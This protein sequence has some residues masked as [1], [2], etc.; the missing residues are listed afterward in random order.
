[1]SA[2]TLPWR[3]AVLG[4]ALAG[5]ALLVTCGSPQGRQTT[6]D[7]LRTG[8]QIAAGAT[9]DQRFSQL[10][11]SWA[12]SIRTADDFLP[13]EEHYIGRAVGASAL[14][15]DRYPLLEDPQVS[16]YVNKVGLAVA[17]SSERVRQTFKGYHFAVLRSD[18]LNAFSA[19]GGFIFITTGMLKETRSEE[20][21][22]GILAHE[23][24]HVTLK[25]GLA[26]I[27]QANMV[28]AGQLMTELYAQHGTDSKKDKRKFKRQLARLSKTFG[29]SADKVVFTLLTGGYG[30]NLEFAADELG[31]RLATAAGFA[32]DGIRSFLSHMPQVGGA[33][34][35]KSTHPAPAA[36]LAR[37]ASLPGDTPPAACLEPRRARHAAVLAR[38]P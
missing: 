22:A 29:E 28:Q 12:R 37:L 4:A 15:G 24:S 30:A 20:E 34:G 18:E 31:T 9:G 11:E 33:G 27:P 5:A 6:G 7:I 8:G 38:L 32:P 2:K 21:L 3:A 26:A 16:A 35:W 25:H 14:A 19:P 13:T 17:F 23:I 36:R 10:G 1:M